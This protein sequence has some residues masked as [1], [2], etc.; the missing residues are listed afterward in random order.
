MSKVDYGTVELK[1]GKEKYTLVPTL[2]CIRKMKKWGVGGPVQAVESLREMDADKMAVIIAAGSSRGQR[3]LE[4]IAQAIHRDGVIHI[5][6]PVAEFL[7]KLL[8][9][10]DRDPEDTKDKGE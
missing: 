7:N 2:D 1:L 4:D 10:T 6:A 8:N 3:E 9:P 5:V